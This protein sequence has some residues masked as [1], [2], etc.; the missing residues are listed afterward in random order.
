[1]YS[2]EPYGV[3][4]ADLAWSPDGTRFALLVIVNQSQQTEYSM[5][6]RTVLVTLK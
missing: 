1:M 3:V 5:P 4:P 6:G 2:D